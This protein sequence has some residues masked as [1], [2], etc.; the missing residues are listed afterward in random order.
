MIRSGKYNK[1]NNRNTRSQNSNPKKKPGIRRHPTDIH[2][3]KPIPPPIGDEIIEDSM[4]H[5]MYLECF[6]AGT[7]VIMKDGP[8]KN[9]E[10]VKVGD[11]VLSYNIHSKKIEPKSITNFFT[12]THDL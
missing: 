11:E 2:S 4:W 5:T 3:K 12:Q 6:V 10:D 8:D 7:K 9:I 1:G